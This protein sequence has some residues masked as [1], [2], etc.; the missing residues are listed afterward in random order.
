M[1]Q[2]TFYD[3][4]ADVIN[5]LT[6]EE[7]GRFSKRICGYAIFERDDVPSKSE[8]E[9]CFWEIIFPTLFDAT[10]IERSG[11][12]PYYLNRKMKHFCFKAAYARM[13]ETF[14][15]N[16]LAGKFM[17][18][19]CAYMFDGTEPTEL[20]KPLNSYFSLFRKS[21]D[22]S[23]HRSESGRMGGARKKKQMT[24]EE[25]IQANPQIEDNIYREEMKENKN[26]ALL[27]KE[28]KASERWKSEKSLYIILRNYE[29]IIA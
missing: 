1:E 26:W 29:E 9:N 8:T 22:L 24:F 11:K 27:D 12:I 21:F 3:I 16:A 5:Q 17:K 13:I 28:L 4:Y 20:D 6:D 7:A 15:D 2:F 25:F 18:A 19:I 23:K 14:K 10:Q